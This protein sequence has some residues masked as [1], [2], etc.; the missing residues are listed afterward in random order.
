MKRSGAK[1]LTTHV[2]SLPGVSSFDPGAPGFK[3]TYPRAGFYPDMLGDNTI[4]N[5]MA[6]LVDSPDAEARGLAF[7]GK[8][9]LDT[10][11]AEA[12]FETGE[13]DPRPELGFEFRLYKG[14][15]TRAYYTGAWGGEDYSV[16]RVYLDVNP[17]RLPR[18]LYAPLPR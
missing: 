4:A 17:V 1:I 8:A 5:A 9:L 16:L 13:R 14:P 7:H 18:P 10:A 15:D 2:G 3:P 12:S 6:R 11:P